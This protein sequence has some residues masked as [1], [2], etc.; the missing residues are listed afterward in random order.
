MCKLKTVLIVAVLLLVAAGFYTYQVNSETKVG[1][2]SQIKSES[3]CEEEYK[4]YYLN[5]G[6]CYYRVD[7]DNVACNCTLFHG[8]K[9]CEKFMWWT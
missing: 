4:K 1:Q 9:R 6:E 7:E 8:R 3:P 2:H 5:G